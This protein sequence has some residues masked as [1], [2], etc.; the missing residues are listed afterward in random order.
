MCVTE[1]YLEGSGYTT[2]EGNPR[3]KLGQIPSDAAINHTPIGF[4][5]GLLEET[6]A[7]P[8]GRTV[9]YVSLRSTGTAARTISTDENGIFRPHTPSAGTIVEIAAAR[10]AGTAVA[11]LV[12]QIGDAASS[13]PPATLAC[14]RARQL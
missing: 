3:T 4:Q 5:G 6:V 7:G 1:G 9:P 2:V 13:K 11:T 14:V 12:D 8:D 10:I